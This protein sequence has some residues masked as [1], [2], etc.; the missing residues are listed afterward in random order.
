[1]ICRTSRSAVLAWT[2]TKM[3]LTRGNAKTC[4]KTTAMSKDILTGITTGEGTCGDCKSV[5]QAKRKELNNITDDQRDG[6]WGEEVCPVCGDR[7]IF[8]PKKS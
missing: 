1:M 4:I 2:R 7:L 8:Y 6:L 3:L 5:V